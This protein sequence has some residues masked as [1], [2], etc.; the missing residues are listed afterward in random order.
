MSSTTQGQAAEQQACGYLTEHGLTLV[1]RNYRCRMGE[2]DLIMRDADALVFVEVR[3][4]R[5]GRHGSPAESITAIKQHRL[6]R[7]AAHYLQRHPVDA[8]CRFDVVGIT[9]DAGKTHIEW[10]RDAFQIDSF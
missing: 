5:A 2:L 3:S 9:R 8:P 4:R 1:A 7:A 10:I 6:Q